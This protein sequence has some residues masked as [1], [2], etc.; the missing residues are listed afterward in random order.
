MA[1]FCGEKPESR[2]GTEKPPTELRKYFTTGTVDPDYARDYAKTQIPTAIVTS[3]GTLYRQGVDIESW[4]GPLC[5]LSAAFAKGEN[6]V[7]SLKWSFDGTGGTV[8]IKASKSNQGRYP[9]GAKDHKGSIGVTKDGDVEGTEIIIPALKFTVTYSH[10]LGVIT[11]AKAFQLGDTAGVVNSDT[12]FTKPAGSFLFLGASGSDGTDA[13]AEITYNFAY[14]KN[15][16][17][18]IISGITVTTKDGWDYGWVYFADKNEAGKPVVAPV[19]VNVERVYDRT[20]F[21]SLFGFG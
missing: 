3:Q 2:T 8:N 16:A 21:V 17:N 1:I 6:E 12:F 9:A 14:S 11:L 20:S 19:S 13:E 7:G 4:E 5:N 10:P 15:L 18:D